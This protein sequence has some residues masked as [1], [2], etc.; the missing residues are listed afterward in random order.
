M[1]FCDSRRFARV[2]LQQDPLNNEPV[3]LLGFDVLTDRPTTEHLAEVL[4]KRRTAIK[5]VLLDQVNF[6]GMAVLATLFLCCAELQAY[7]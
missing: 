7:A 3:S 5:S 4:G 1:A 2:R 6:G